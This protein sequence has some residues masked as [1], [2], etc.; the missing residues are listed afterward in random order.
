MTDYVLIS[1]IILVHINSLCVGYFV[2]KSVCFNSE[3]NSSKNKSFFTQQK[4]QIKDRGISI[5]S[6]KFVADINTDGMEKKYLGLGDTQISN[7]NI[8]GSIN[9]LKNMKG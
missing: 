3:N 1:L 8:S 6:T 7:D 4:E 9:K 5:D 2:G